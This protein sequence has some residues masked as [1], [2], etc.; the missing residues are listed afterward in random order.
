MNDIMVRVSKGRFGFGFCILDVNIA[1]IE[2]SFVAFAT[3]HILLNTRE[4]KL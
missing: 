1:L 4:R 2:S 3:L